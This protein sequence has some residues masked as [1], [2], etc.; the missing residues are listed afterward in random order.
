MPKKM[1]PAESALWEVLRGKQFGYRFRRQHP[2]GEYIPDFVCLPKRLVI[3]VDG[4]YH[5]E[6]EQIKKDGLRTTRLNEM[7]FNVIRF[8]NEEIL[9]NILGVIN[10]IKDKRNE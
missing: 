10:Q 3:E 5:S 6:Y 2:I 1:T 4:G 9:G 8:S 7:G